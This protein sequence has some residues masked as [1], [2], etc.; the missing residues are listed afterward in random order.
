MRISPPKVSPE[1]TPAGRPPQGS[2]E[3]DAYRE[4]SFVL[5]AEVE[6]VLRGLRIEGA[7]AAASAGAKFRTP[8]TAAL[9]ALW[10]RSWLLRLE[11]LHAVQWGRYAAAPPLV[12]AALDAIAAAAAVPGSPEWE[13]WIGRAVALRPDAHGFE[14][15]LGPFRSAETLAA[16][17]E[18]GALYQECTLFTMPHFASTLLLAAEESNPERFAVSFGDRAFHLGL[19]ELQLGWLL[20]AGL[21]AVAFAEEWGR[22]G[23]LAPVDREEAD[24]FRREAEAALGR[25]ERC[26]LER[27]TVS[28]EER[29]IVVNWRR[30]PGSAPRRFVLEE[31]R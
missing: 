22:T 30:Q 2:A 17:P 26:R 1:P 20:R 13:A 4:T 29:T 3:A 8:R 11:A 25:W 12:R 27:A 18:L 10:S 14:V 7:A 6:A 16:D 19:A 28:G 9:L 5:G 15:P 24:G 21:R 31:G 23:A